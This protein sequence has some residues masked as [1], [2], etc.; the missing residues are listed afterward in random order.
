[1]ELKDLPPNAS[2]QERESAFKKLLTAF[3]KAVGQAEILKDYREHEEYEKP[4]DKKRR[5]KRQNE[6]ARLKTKLKENFPKSRGKT[7]R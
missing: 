4:S 5:T 2:Y 3:N 1:M 7:E 6:I